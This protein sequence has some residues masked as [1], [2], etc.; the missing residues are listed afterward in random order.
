MPSSVTSRLQID[1]PIS[2]EELAVIRAALE[3]ASTRPIASHSIESVGHLHA[4][5]K[6]GCG[7]DSV[8]FA[9]HDSANPSFPIADGIGT[10]SQGEE[11]GLIVWG[12]QDAITG[13]E[14]YAL[15]GEGHKLP[16]PETIHG[17]DHQRT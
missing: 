9:A 15:G 4:I 14:V 1:R 8:D 13:L 10:T 2:A 7:C 17:W 12:T 16:I 5:A 6:C 11:V 3:R